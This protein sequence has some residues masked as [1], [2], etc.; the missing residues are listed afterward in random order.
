MTPAWIALVLSVTLLTQAG[1]TTPAVDERQ[2]IAS[3]RAQVQA[4]Y[5]RRERECHERFM[6]SDCLE[7]ARRERRE[8]MERLRYQDVILDEAQRKQRAVQR[9]QNIRSKERSDPP[10]MRKRL[11][12]AA[13]V[14]FR[15]E[16]AIPASAA[17]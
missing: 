14:R 7:Q 10:P 13:Q 1:A 11:S 8:S 3:E 6:V 16:P 4:A 2:R 17:R 5:A 9:M 12:D 15:A